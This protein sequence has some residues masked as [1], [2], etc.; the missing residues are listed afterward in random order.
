ME[1]I[2]LMLI[3]GENVGDGPFILAAAIGSVIGGAASYKI[4]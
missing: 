4:L 1:K 3:F 2:I